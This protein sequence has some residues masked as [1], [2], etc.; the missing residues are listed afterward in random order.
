MR[1]PRDIFTC[2]SLA[3]ALC[4]A[5]LVLTLA[6]A[7]RAGA[8]TPSDRRSLAVAGDK[9]QVP[10]PKSE[11]RYKPG[12]DDKKKS[13]SDDDSKS[14]GF[15]ES[16][17]DVILSGAFDGICTP[18]HS[19]QP[20]PAP[21]TPRSPGSPDP[22][23]PP[24][25][26]DLVLDVH[27]WAVSDH[28][29]LTAAAPGDSVM[30]LRSPL[31]QGRPDED[32]GHLPAGTEV[33]I[34]ETHTLTRGVELR[35]RPVDAVEPVGWIPSAALATAPPAVAASPTADAAALPP[36]PYPPQQGPARAGVQVVLGIGAFGNRELH[37]E[38]RQPGFRGALGY[39]RFERGGWLWGPSLGVRGYTG[40]AQMNYE[41]SVTTDWPGASEYTIGDFAMVA[42]QREGK[43]RGFGCGWSAGPA[44][45]CM[46]ELS[47]V[48]TIDN[49]TGALRRHDETL[50]R[51]TAGG[52][53]SA[54]ADWNVAPGADVGLRIEGYVAGWDGREEKSLTSDFI[55]A[56]LCGF[57]VGLCVNFRIY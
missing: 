18:S 56:P 45:F 26:Q 35:V 25:S 1:P 47:D 21:F 51:W 48:T 28:G 36:H 54:T 5:L 49:T 32:A 7:R 30:L 46:Y 41:S 38:F 19:A 37:H 44:I 42:G 29:W 43:H 20:P 34:I 3:S 10:K 12:A 39:Q 9:K 40:N 57:D 6:P 15:F 23:A 24:S 52:V 14:G 50:G 13:D 31:E 16:C 22:L 33:V 27:A 11:P 53:A 55:H 8:A 2:R 17:L 4:C